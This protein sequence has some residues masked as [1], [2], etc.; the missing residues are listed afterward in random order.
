MLS[1]DWVIQDHY[2]SKMN[3]LGKDVFW[4]EKNCGSL[5]PSQIISDTDRGAIIL[6]HFLTAI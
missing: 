2:K 5:P 1:T 3:E 6:Y 4:S